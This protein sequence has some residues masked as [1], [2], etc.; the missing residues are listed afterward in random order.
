MKVRKCT[1]D[2]NSDLRIIGILLLHIHES[3]WRFSLET[4]NIPRL[5]GAG[6]EPQAVVYMT[7]AGSYRAN[8]S[9]VPPIVDLFSSWLADDCKNSVYWTS[10]RSTIFETN[11]RI[12]VVSAILTSRVGLT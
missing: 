10:R 1:V 3:R 2:S 5:E 8:I 4:G 6:V 7:F 12:G 11:R 9:Y